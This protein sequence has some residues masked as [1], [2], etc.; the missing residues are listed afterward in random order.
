MLK[1]TETDATHACKDDQICA[2]LKTGI[3][4][5]VHMVKSIWDTHST[6]EKWGFLLV[7]AKNAFNKIN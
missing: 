6:E 7:V 1:V 3:N 2:G 5:A 4:G